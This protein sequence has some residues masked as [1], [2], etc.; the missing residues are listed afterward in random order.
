MHV[1]VLSAMSEGAIRERS[2][3]M[4]APTFSLSN[5]EQF[6][7]RYLPDIG[8]GTSFPD[9]LDPP[10]GCAFHPR[11][12]KALPVCRTQAPHRIA[13]PRGQVECHLYDE[14]PVA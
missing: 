8:L 6:R 14:A 3:V 13:G 7:A 2:D 11:C 10:S 12:A 5:L 1:P 9:P 4:S